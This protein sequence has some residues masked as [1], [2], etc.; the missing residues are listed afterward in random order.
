MLQKEL[1]YIKYKIYSI[2]DNINNSRCIYNSLLY[3]H[4]SSDQKIY[5]HDFWK[6]IDNKLT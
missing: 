5:R 1:K 3:N 6:I 2:N 4:L